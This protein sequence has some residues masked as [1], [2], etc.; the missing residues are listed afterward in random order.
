[1][2]NELFPTLKCS[3]LINVRWCHT[4]FISKTSLRI[5][6]IFILL[7]NFVGQHFVKFERSS[8][9]FGVCL[10]AFLSYGIMKIF[11][12]GSQPQMSWIYARPVVATVANVQFFWSWTKMHNVRRAV[13]RFLFAINPDRSVS[14]IAAT[15]NPKDALPNRNTFLKEPVFYGLHD[16]L[17]LLKLKLSTET[18]E[19]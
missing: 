8:E 16:T 15:T 10:K 1:M 2:I 5:A 13:S 18:R 14:G 12:S 17:L 3:D 7:S 9:M 6:A 11:F 19:N 4:V